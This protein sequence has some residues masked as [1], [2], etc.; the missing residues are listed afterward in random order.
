[1]RKFGIIVI[2]IVV[3]LVGAA[4]LVPHLI[5]INQY[6][7]RIQTQL[8]KRLGRQVTLGEMKL[9]LF[10]PS[11]QVEN[12]TIAEDPRVTSSRPFATMEKLAVSVKLWPLLHKEIDVKSL[13]LD[14]P[15][16]E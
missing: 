15:H 11:F 14:R 13:E 8:E 4:L 9:S 5:D 16:I 12:A 3:L 10:P 7:G 2:V 1:M 6:H